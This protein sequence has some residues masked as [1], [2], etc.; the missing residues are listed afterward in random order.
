MNTLVR[1]Y[2]YEDANFEEVVILSEAPEKKWSDV[3]KLVPHCPKGW[4]ALS[5]VPSEDRIEFSRSFWL[6][7]LP[8]H[9]KAH[10]VISEFFDSLDD[11]GVVISKKKESWV[12]QLVYSFM[13]N[14]CFFRGL[15][16]ASD[17]DIED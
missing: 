6:K 8:F 5:R 9:P 4:F 16:P 12:P 17:T 13:D 1:R 11:I 10:A 3:E 2:F 14:S 7:R 15:P